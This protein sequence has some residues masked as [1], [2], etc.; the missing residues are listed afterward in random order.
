MCVNPWNI[1][2]SLGRDIGVTGYSLSHLEWL[3]DF[4]PIGGEEPSISKD[5]FGWYD[6]GIRPHLG[7]KAEKGKLK[8]IAFSMD[9]YWLG[10]FLCQ[11][12]E[13]APTTVVMVE[14]TWIGGHQLQARVS[15]LVRCIIHE[16]QLFCLNSSISRYK[17]GQLFLYPPS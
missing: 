8:R 2:Q 16:S 13:F 17:M 4:F 6:I 10:K 12:S 5:C 11:N 3:K 15:S 9:L 1:Y 7:D 14:R